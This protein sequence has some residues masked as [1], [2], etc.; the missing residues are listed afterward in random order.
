MLFVFSWSTTANELWKITRAFAYVRSATNV[1]KNGQHSMQRTRK[2][3]G[4][5]DAIMLRMKL[6]KKVI[7]EYDIPDILQLFLFLIFLACVLSPQYEGVTFSRFCIDLSLFL[8]WLALCSPLFAWRWAQFPYGRLSCTC[9]VFVTVFV[10]CLLSLS[11]SLS[12]SFV[13]V[14][15]FCFCLCHCL[16]LCLCLCWFVFVLTLSFVFVFVFVFV[17]CLCLTLTLTLNLTVNVNVSLTL[18]PIPTL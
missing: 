13:F 16:C 4:T 15:V 17:F 3:T 2:G 9:L 7:R 18:I 8:S 6:K 11:L 12:L 14:F 5:R 10:F 1:A